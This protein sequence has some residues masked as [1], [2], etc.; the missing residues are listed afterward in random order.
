MRAARAYHLPPQGGW[1]SDESVETAAQRETMEEAGVRGELE[2]RRGRQGRRCL[3]GLAS[4]RPMQ[5]V[6]VPPPPPLL[7]PALGSLEAGACTDHPQ[8]I[9]PPPS[10]WPQGEMLG[11][12]PF[13]SRKAERLQTAHQGRC[14]AH[15][16]ALRVTEELQVCGADARAGHG[17]AGGQQ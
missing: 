9:P 3:H 16:F 14:I 4:T 11:A 6:A 15:V 13:H 17:A 2:V 10:M 5:M 1:E 8:P 7:L 12:F